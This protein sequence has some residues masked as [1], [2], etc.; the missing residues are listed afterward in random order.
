MVL[1][2]FLVFCRILLLRGTA[3]DIVIPVPFT[4]KSFVIQANFLQTILAKTEFE[5]V[6]NIIQAF[7]WYVISAFIVKDVSSKFT[8]IKSGNVEDIQNT[9]IKEEML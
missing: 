7:W 8:K 1:I 4:N 2:I 9:N 5:W 3:K 6:Y